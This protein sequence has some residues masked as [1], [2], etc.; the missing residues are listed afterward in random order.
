MRVLSIDP[1]LAG[2][3]VVIST[4]CVCDEELGLRGCGSC[5]RGL[6]LVA[7]WAWRPLDRKAGRVWRVDSPWTDAPS[8]PSSLVDAL[9]HER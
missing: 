2:A 8:P 4:D 1:G 3:A 9:A 5:Q 6:R 7:A